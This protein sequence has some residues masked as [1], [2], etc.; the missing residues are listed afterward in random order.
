MVIRD[1]RKDKFR[2]PHASAADRDA[3]LQTVDRVLY[4][5]PDCR[6]SH[7]VTVDGCP[8]AA[9]AARETA[10]VD[11]KQAQKVA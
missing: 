10:A 7:F 6:R 4:D 2:F 5:C 1:D 8:D 3:A 11:G 9:T